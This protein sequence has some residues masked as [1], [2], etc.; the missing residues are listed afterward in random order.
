MAKYDPLRPSLR[1]VSLAMTFK[2][3]SDSRQLDMT[4][5]T[6]GADAFI[7]AILFKFLSILWRVKCEPNRPLNMYSLLLSGF[8]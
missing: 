5:K 8:M 6:V 3:L 1:P 7:R 2:A 4:P